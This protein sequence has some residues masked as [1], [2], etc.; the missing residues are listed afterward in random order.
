MLNSV[1]E[2]VE[3]FVVQNGIP[4]SE[5]P[6]KITNNI[7]LATS[8]EEIL[9]LLSET[10]KE[11]FRGWVISDN[12][13]SDGLSNDFSIL[14]KISIL[15]KLIY[16]K[17][18]EQSKSPDKRF[19]IILSGCGTSG[20]LAYLCSQTFSLFLKSIYPALDYNVC[21][22]IIAGGDYALV[23]SVE[24]VE[25]KPKVGAQLLK[26]I[27]DEH[28]NTE[29][30]YLGITCGF[31]APF[32]AGQIDFCLNKENNRNILA[33][34]IIGFNPVEMTRK[35]SPI[36][37]NNENFYDLMKKLENMERQDPNKYFIFNPLIGPEPITGSSRMKSGTTTKILIDLIFT[38]ALVYLDKRENSNELEMLDFYEKIL[39]VLYA[40]NTKKNLGNIIDNSCEALRNLKHGGSINY[41]S[42]SERLGLLCCVDASECLPTYGAGKNDIKGFVSAKN[43]KSLTQKWQGFIKN[44]PTVW[45]QNIIDHLENFNSDKCVFI[46]IESD[47]EFQS[48]QEIIDKENLE[49]ILLEKTQCKIYKINLSSKNIEHT[50]RIKVLEM[51]ELSIIYR[52]AS[53]MYSSYFSNC[54][55]EF[56]LKLILNAISTGAHVLY[57]KTYENIMIDVKVSNIKLYWRAC[58]IL[59]KF[60]SEL[61]KEQ[62]EDYLL[63]SIYSGEKLTNEKNDIEKHIEVAT[64]KEFIVPKA[65]IM[66]LTGCN[67]SNA[68]LL[69]D[70]SRN[71][72]RNCIFKLKN[73]I[74]NK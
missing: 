3:E 68:T 9:N 25:D 44:C 72:V 60:C 20:R 74:Q 26:N 21:D 43:A 40:E 17:I 5:L 46:L 56:T 53:K 24:S 69:L 63:A 65:L 45:S 13:K 39:N 36:N 2:K 67:Y 27:L 29:C 48:D 14:K 10:D 33:C 64:G 12:L 55:Q 28:P 49:K 70:E 16:E 19:K 15:S 54:L 58:G 35:T 11:I 47:D 41:L 57:G 6:N 61:N 34:G 1:R 31:S 59:K 66:A 18:H 32:V 73:K 52:E 22:Y 37:E 4:V 38:K 8:G 71:S 51:N 7:D 42:D 62:C 50:N 23:N 30:V